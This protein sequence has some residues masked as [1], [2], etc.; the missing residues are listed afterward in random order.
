MMTE[1]G[2]TAVSAARFL[3][4]GR[5]QGVFYRMWTREQAGLLALRGWVRNLADGRVEALAMGAEEAIDE[6]ERRLHQGP[7]AAR[8]TSVQRQA[9]APDAQ[10]LA[11]GGFTIRR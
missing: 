7:P 3:V 1:V 10:A 2:H 8:V 6:L 5:V 9:V 11:E 4:D